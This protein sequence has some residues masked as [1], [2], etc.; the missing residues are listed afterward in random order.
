MGFF[1]DFTLPS[2]SDITVR[3]REATVSDAIDFSDIDPGC[4][5]ES[6]TLFLERMQA[7]EKYTDPRTWTGEDRRYALFMYLLNTT[8]D[9]GLAMTYS[10]SFCNREHTVDIAFSDIVSSYVSMDGKPFRD[11]VHEGHAILVHPLLGR[12]LEVLEKTRISIQYTENNSHN[13]ARKKRA[14]LVM[15]RV[16]SSIDMPSCAGNSE[17]ERRPHVEKFLLDM[18][19]SEFRMFMIKVSTAH[20]AMRHGL[21]MEYDSDGRLVLLVP[22]V[23]CPEGGGVTTLRYPFRAGDYIPHV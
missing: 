1:P 14:Q 9:R 7:R 19:A 22:N 16:L 5:E 21:A 23:K 10:C 8:S 17:M 20:E 13:V 12:D 11:I 6:T 15:M 2:N 18:P 4:E 3:L